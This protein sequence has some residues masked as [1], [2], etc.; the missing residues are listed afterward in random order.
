MPIVLPPIDAEAIDAPNI[1]LCGVEP[2][3]I[4]LEFII[5]LPKLKVHLS[6]KRLFFV[7]DLF[8]QKDY[9]YKSTTNAI[10]PIFGP[11][12]WLYSPCNA[13]I[14]HTWAHKPITRPYICTNS[15]CYEP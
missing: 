2:Q 6:L 15:P 12:S 3:L 14:A 5:Y 10:G 9:L 1:D 11:D 8:L 4:K 13:S 7:K